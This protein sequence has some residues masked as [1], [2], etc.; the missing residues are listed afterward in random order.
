MV[1]HLQMQPRGHLSHAVVRGWRVP[2]HKVNHYLKRNSHIALMVNQNAPAKDVPRRRMLIPKSLQLPDDLRLSDE[3]IQLCGQFVIGC[4]GGGSWCPDGTNAVFVASPQV[5]SWFNE[6][7]CARFLLEQG[8]FRQ[9]FKFLDISFRQLKELLCD[10]D[11]TVFILVYFTILE[12]PDSISQRMCAY[13]AEMSGILFPLNHP[14]NLIWSRLSQAG[15]RALFDQA[16]NI[17]ECYFDLLKQ[18]FSHHEHGILNFSRIFYRLVFHLRFLDSDAFIPKLAEIIT[19]LEG[20]DGCIK[21]VLITKIAMADD[22]CRRA[23]YDT[24]TTL[25]K[26]IEAEIYYVHGTNGN[27]R[28]RE[29]SVA[30]DM[31]MNIY[32]TY[33]EIYRASGAVEDAVGVSKKL[34]QLCISSECSTNARCTDTISDV[35]SYFVKIGKI[36]EAQSLLRVLEESGDQIQEELRLYLQETETIN[37]F[38]WESSNSL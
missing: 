31:L 18:R 6:T 12:L 16:W 14:M 23:E 33:F 11:P 35:Q 34:L 5:N 19:G 2:P 1:R 21:D 29:E 17:L 7:A 30:Y 38:S 22:L 8:R 3:V 13:V 28:G 24:A 15:N 20:L 32:L 25:L 37:N 10:P 4:S 36:D 9:A 27:L 26:D